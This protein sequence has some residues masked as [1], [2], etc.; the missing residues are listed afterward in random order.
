MSLTRR[1]VTALVAGLI[2]GIIVSAVNDAR[3]MSAVS[4]IQPLG[5]LWVNAI[6]MT[7]VPLIFSL[8]VV[9]VASASSAAAVGRMGAQT[10]GLFLVLLTCS[11]II[12]VLLAPPIFSLLHIDP[13]VAASLRG[14]ASTAAVESARQLPSF[15]Q[16]LDGAGSDE[17]SQDRG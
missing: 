5:I 3:L 13:A 4:F 10:V 16:W 9:S 17:S 8:L 2:L 11:A 12:G 14:N 1:V 6:R 7:V 15:S